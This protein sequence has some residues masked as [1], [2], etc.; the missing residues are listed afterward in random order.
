[1]QISQ[2]AL[3]RFSGHIGSAG[4]DFDPGDSVG[5]S[6]SLCVRSPV[7]DL[8]KP[9]MRVRGGV[10]QASLISIYLNERWHKLPHPLSAVKI[11]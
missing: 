2:A 3:L 10:G 1:M 5:E 6:G 11:K 8:M 4:M 9:E 7:A